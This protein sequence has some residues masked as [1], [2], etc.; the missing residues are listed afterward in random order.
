MID[1]KDKEKAKTILIQ[2]SG[3]KEDYV[4]TLK[5]MVY[6]LSNQNPEH[7]PPGMHMLMYSNLM[8]D[9]LNQIMNE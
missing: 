9:M 7:R 6:M 3:D 1:C 5:A 4:N 2:F 8:D